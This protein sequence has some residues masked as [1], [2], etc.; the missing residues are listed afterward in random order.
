LTYQQRVSVPSSPKNRE[1]FGI[2][3][4]R[5]VYL[6]AQHLGKFHPD[7]DPILAGILR[8]DGKGVVVITEDRNGGFIARQLRRRFSATI[9]DVARRILF[10]PFQATPDYL[11][12]TAAADVLL[13]PLHFG[14]VNTSYDG[15][16][17]N[18][19]I[20]TLPSR[21]QRGRY[22]LG[23]YR[24]MGVSECVAS[25]PQQYVDIAVAM[26]TDAEFRAHVVEKIRLA[27]P[28]LFEDMEAVREH[29]RIFGALVE[30]ARSGCRRDG[31]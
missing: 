11:S 10:L 13:D 15:F 7:F 3:S 8:A 4:D 28:V 21:F 31:S 5:H 16:S 2:A 29:E 18:K 24:K 20:V 17:F 27:S 14:G 25:N 6:C 26:G 30:E 23:C 22:T 12:L 19:P 1:F 9:P